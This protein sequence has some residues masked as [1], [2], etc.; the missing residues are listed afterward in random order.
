[1]DAWTVS[2]RGERATPQSSYI[3]PFLYFTIKVQPLNE[4]NISF[5]PIQKNKPFPYDY[6]E[7]YGFFIT[8]LP[9]LYRSSQ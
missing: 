2:L 7:K 5:N 1:M 9:R 4:I 3:N 6:N 8:G